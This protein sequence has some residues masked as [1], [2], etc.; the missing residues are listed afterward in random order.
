VSRS[1]DDALLVLPRVVDLLARRAEETRRGG[2]DVEA[3]RW[4][5]CARLGER[6]AEEVRRLRAERAALGERLGRRYGN[7]AEL[8]LLAERFCVLHAAACCLAHRALSSPWIAE[9]LDGAAPL[10]LCLQR[11][12]HASHP[13]DTVVEESD[14]DSVAEVLLR[15]HDEHR[16]FGYR[17]F[18][19]AKSTDSTRSP[20]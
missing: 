20:E 7:S 18:A 10:L 15:L 9:P 8:F 17:Q 16:S 1:G 13:N 14:V 3:D 5:R 12:W 4:Q 11:L 19:L 2:D 6:F